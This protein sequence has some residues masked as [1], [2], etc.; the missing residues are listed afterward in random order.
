[1]QNVDSGCNDKRLVKSRCTLELRGALEKLSGGKLLDIGCGG[2]FFID[3]VD[4]LEFKVIGIDISDGAIEICKE[5]YKDKQGQYQ[6][7]VYDAKEFVIKPE[8]YDVIVAKSSIVCMRR[9]NVLNILSDIKRGLKHGGVAHLEVF[10][11]KNPLYL[12]HDR[13]LLEGESTYFYPSCNNFMYFFA[14]GELRERFKDFQLLEYKEFKIH[15]KYPFPHWHH[16][17]RLSCRKL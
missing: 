13:I 16:E 5:R 15:E 17:A 14:P 1:M 4:D 6:F 9:E 2:G 10:T 7:I 3:E 8:E 11:T 12:Q